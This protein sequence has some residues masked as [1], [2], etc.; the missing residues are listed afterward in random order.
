MQQ[1]TVFNDLGEWQNAAES[2]QIAGQIA[3]DVYRENPGLTQALR[4]VSSSH[5]QVGDALDTL[6]DYRGALENYRYALKAATEARAGN[7]NSSELRYSE[8]KDTVKV[9]IALHK[10]G[11]V[12]DSF[13]LVRKGIGLARE[14]IAEDRGRAATIT[15]GTELFQQGADFLGSKGRPEEAIAVYQEALEILERLAAETIHDSSVPY[16]IARYEAAVGDLY[17]IFDSETKT[18]KATSQAALLKARNRYQQ[19]LD[20]LQ[21]QQRLGAILSDLANRLEEVSQKL[22]ACEAALAKLKN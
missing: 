16:L 14:Y 3:E 5:N 15:Y 1:G 22:S 20:I 19:S 21:G 6:G 8:A 4:F 10:V 9:G 7:P 18:V 17:A 11:Q 2:Y 12:S 13:E